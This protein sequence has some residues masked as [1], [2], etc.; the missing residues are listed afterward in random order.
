M[1]FGLEI[2]NLNNQIQEKQL[3]RQTAREL[4]LSARRRRD[5]AEADAQSESEKV[6]AFDSTIAK[7]ITARDALAALNAT[8]KLQQQVDESNAR[9]RVPAP[10]EHVYQ[11]VKEF[12][13]LGKSGTSYTIEVVCVDREHFVFKCD[14]MA[15]RFTK[16]ELADGKT[17]KHIERFTAARTRGLFEAVSRLGAKA[18]GI[19]RPSYKTENLA[20]V[21]KYNFGGDI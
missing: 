13:V 5:A 7:L 19:I 15:F 10:A 9:T 12:D 2:R 21:S 8:E 17:C 20:F 16:G 4:V 1:D 3:R 18:E 6:C 14:C 11:T